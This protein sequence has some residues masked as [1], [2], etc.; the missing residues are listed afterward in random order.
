[1]RDWRF[2]IG[3]SGVVCEAGIREVG[4]LY[5]NELFRRAWSNQLISSAYLRT[6][7]SC[8]RFEHSVIVGSLSSLFC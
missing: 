8:S 6:L 4:R 1:M 3:S 2:E 5:I 7:Y